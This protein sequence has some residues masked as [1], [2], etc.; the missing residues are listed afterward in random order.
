MLHAFRFENADECWLALARE[1]L[2]NPESQIQDG[3]GG[4]TKELLH[5]GFSI[6]NPRE[7]WIVSREPALNPAFAIAEVIWIIN[8]RNDARFLNYFNRSLPKYA[9]NTES[10]P[11]AYGHRLCKHFG[12]NQL[13]RVYEALNA[14]KGSRQAVLQIWAPEIDMPNADGNA[15]SQDIP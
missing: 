14:N 2:C 10:Y 5:V 9:G 1:L 7:R 3:R 12:Q 11:G 4:P 6:A 13:S 8:G 15:T